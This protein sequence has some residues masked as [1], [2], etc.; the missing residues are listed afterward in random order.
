MEPDWFAAAV[1]AVESAAAEAQAS[2]VAVVESLVPAREGRRT[3]ETLLELMDRM[4]DAG[5]PEARRAAGLA[6]QRYEHTIQALRAEI[7][8]HLVTDEGLSL[9]EAA[10]SMRISRQRAA[11]ILASVSDPLEATPPGLEEAADSPGEGA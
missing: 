4:N 1:Q 2:L 5:S 9:S 10:R 8:R 11:R 7:I 6:L 3:G